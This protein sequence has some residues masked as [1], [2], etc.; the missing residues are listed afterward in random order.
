MQPTSSLPK[1]ELNVFAGDPVG[2]P[3]GSSVLDAVIHNVLINNITKMNHLITLAK[4]KTEGAS[5]DGA[6]YRLI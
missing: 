4:N 3:E 6:L 5:A 1:L 2:W